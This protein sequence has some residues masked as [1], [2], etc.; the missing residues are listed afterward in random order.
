MKSRASVLAFVVTLAA[1]LLR[2]AG[3]AK[4]PVAAKV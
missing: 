1:V 4:K 2:I 3:C